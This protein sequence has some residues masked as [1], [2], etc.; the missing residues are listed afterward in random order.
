MLEQ[1]FNPMKCNPKVVSENGMF[2]SVKGRRPAYVRNRCN[3]LLKVIND[4][5]QAP[6]WITTDKHQ[7][8][9][10]ICALKA[11]LNERDCSRKFEAITEDIFSELYFTEGHFVDR[12]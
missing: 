4:M 2:W 9:M 5:K 8:Q 3:H 7:E 11:G 10:T 6:Q 12:Q 1:S